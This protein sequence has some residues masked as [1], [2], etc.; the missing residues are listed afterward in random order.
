MKRG[1]SARRGWANTPVA[2]RPPAN[3]TP[4][5]SSWMLMLISVGRVRTPSS[6][7]SRR[8]WGYVRSLWTMNPVSTASTIAGGIGDVVGVGMAAET[9]VGFVEGHVVLLREHVGRGQTGDT[10]ADDGE[11]ATVAEVVL[12]MT[13]ARSPGRRTRRSDPSRRRRRS[14]SLVTTGAPQRRIRSASPASNATLT[15]SAVRSAVP[16]GASIIAA[17]DTRSRAPI[18][19]PR[20]LVRATPVDRPSQAGEPC[21]GERSRQRVRA[22]RGGEG[23]EDSGDQCR[24]HVELLSLRI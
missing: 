21:E 3:S 10:G 20:F 16:A 17:P 2:P 7:N 22:V 6:P 18:A 15:A 5:R 14:P 12:F 9:I 24:S 11:R 13:V 1:S 8:R 19:Q 23:P 4:L